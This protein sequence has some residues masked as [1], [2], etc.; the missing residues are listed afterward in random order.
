[1]NLNV[2]TCWSVRGSHTT[3]SRG[4][5]KA[6]W[7]WLVKVPGVK[8][9][10]TAVAPVWDANFRIA[11][12]QIPT[13]H[14]ISSFTPKWLV[15]HRS[16]IE[17]SQSHCQFTLSIQVINPNSCFS[18]TNNPLSQRFWTH[19]FK[20]LFIMHKMWMKSQRSL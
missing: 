17:V 10:A 18:V 1:M 20:N 12:Y 5:L 14:N 16:R 11:R 2:F 19:Q 15:G 13:R 6:A 9:P 7:I 4:S 3:S 8:R